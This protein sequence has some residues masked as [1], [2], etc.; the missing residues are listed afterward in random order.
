LTGEC[1][2][3]IG[4]PSLTFEKGV[5]YANCEIPADFMND[6]SYAISLMIVKD[7]STVMYNFEEVL[8]F[9]I[10]DYREETSWYGKWPGYVRPKIDFP[11]TQLELEQC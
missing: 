6:G 5:V 3:N 8:I 1:I 2:F 4:T 7:K 10:E 9:E 11:I